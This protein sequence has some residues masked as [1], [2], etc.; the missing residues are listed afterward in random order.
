MEKI[1]PKQTTKNSDSSTESLPVTVGKEKLWT[2]INRHAKRIGKELTENALKLYYSAKDENTP[3]WAKTVI[4][5]ALAYF[6]LPLDAIPDF[7]PIGYTDDLT[8]L[9]AAITT[10]SLYITKEH[11]EKAKQKIKQWFPE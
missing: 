9:I 8:T 10:V 5:G 7:L 11:A 4:Y 1:M 2:K 3:A 6:I